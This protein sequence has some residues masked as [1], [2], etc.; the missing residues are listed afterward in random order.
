[1][2]DSY[3]STWRAY[4]QNDI[5]VL[6]HITRPRVLALTFW[7]WLPH[8]FYI[9]STHF[10]YKWV[11]TLMLALLV[12]LLLHLWNSQ[13]PLCPWDCLGTILIPSWF[14]QPINRLIG[15]ELTVTDNANS[16]LSVVHCFLFFF[17]EGRF[18]FWSYIW[19]AQ[20]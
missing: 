18:M 3:T 14:S 15:I 4:N 16:P 11:I 10:H 2:G 7:L 5:D 19:L 13:I 1:M 17:E 20:Y 9:D 6:I 12:I 8:A